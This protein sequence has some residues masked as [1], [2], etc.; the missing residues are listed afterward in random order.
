MFV[1]N[2]EYHVA[3][4][5][6]GATSCGDLHGSIGHEVEREPDAKPRRRI[7]FRPPEKVIDDPS[8]MLL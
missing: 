4:D 5:L 6:D 2:I 8:W 7:G 3:L 1:P